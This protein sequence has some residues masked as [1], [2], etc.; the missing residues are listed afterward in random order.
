MLR[1]LL[2]CTIVTLVIVRASDSS[3]AE[4]DDGIS[5]NKPPA[6]NRDDA[7]LAKQLVRPI[8]EKDV[9]RM[10]RLRSRYQQSITTSSYSSR[11]NGL[12]LGD[13]PIL[14]GSGI[15]TIDL[16]IRGRATLQT[17][18]EQCCRVK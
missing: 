11:R 2:F 5:T 16:E 10:F 7:V 18:M 3:C 9:L 4:D 1:L 13:W 12:T 6:A 17:T 8:K 15:T 14:F